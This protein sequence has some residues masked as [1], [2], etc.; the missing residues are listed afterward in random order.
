MHNVAPYLN[1]TLMLGWTILAVWYGA[2]LFR[3]LYSTIER[4][5]NTTERLNHYMNKMEEVYAARNSI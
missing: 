3:T 1:L 4:V 5:N 2:P